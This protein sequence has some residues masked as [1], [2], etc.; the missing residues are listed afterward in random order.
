MQ[1]RNRWLKS[2]SSRIFLR[3]CCQFFAI[4]SNISAIASMTAT[5][6]LFWQAFAMRTWNSMCRATR[7]LLKARSFSHKVMLASMAFRSSVVLRRA[8]FLIRTGSSVRRKSIISSSV[9][10]P[11]WKQEIRDFP[12]RFTSGA[13][14]KFPPYLPL[15][16]RINPRTSISRSASR[17]ATLLTLNWAAIFSSVGS[18]V[19]CFS[20]PSRT[21]CSIT[22]II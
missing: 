16:F 6:N 20:E 2:I 10:V 11:N 17:T 14:T 9:R 15:A 8:A 4:S 12:T 7:V 13:E 19:P 5:N 21:A 3:S 22:V 1:S 18:F